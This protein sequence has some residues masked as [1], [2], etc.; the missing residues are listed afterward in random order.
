MQ[1]LKDRN[2]EKSIIKRLEELNKLCLDGERVKP[3][4]KVFTGL[5]GIIRVQYSVI[6]DGETLMEARYKKIKSF[7]KEAL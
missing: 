1:R 4:L 6:A 7:L 5:R 2:Q 3:S